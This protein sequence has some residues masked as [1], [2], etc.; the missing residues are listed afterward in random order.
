MVCRAKEG[1]SIGVR[2]SW[3]LG[4]GGGAG[5]VDYIC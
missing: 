1:G 4:N 2:G 3:G 5:S